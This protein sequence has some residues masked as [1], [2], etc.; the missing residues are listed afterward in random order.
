MFSD[1]RGVIAELALQTLIVSLE[2]EL[3]DNSNTSPNLNTNTDTCSAD[4]KNTAAEGCQVTGL[5]DVFRL[6][7]QLR[8]I[9]SKNVFLT[10]IYEH[11]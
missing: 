1:Q 9:D 8:K 2:Q 6:A 7:S 10:L 3:I 5:A 4:Y 11:F